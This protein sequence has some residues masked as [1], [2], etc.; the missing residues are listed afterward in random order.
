MTAKIP[1]R[2]WCEKLQREID[3]GE[4]LR[5]YIDCDTVYGPYPRKGRK[6]QVILGKLYLAGS[7]CPLLGQ[8]YTCL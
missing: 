4:I 7:R 8:D 5:L 1:K 3:I 6:N 2:Y